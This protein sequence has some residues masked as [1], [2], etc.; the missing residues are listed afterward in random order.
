MPLD[1]YSYNTGIIFGFRFGK[2]NENASWSLLGVH[3][4]KHFFQQ[5]SKESCFMS[6]EQS[7]A[8][9]LFK[10]IQTLFKNSTVGSE[11]LS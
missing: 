7:F 6:M 2:G 4:I 10:P 3:Q 1:V 11:F 8:K 9:T 5:S